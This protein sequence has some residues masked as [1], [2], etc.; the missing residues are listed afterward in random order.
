LEH[1]QADQNPNVRE[2]D[3]GESSNHEWWPSYWFLRHVYAAA[4]PRA[5]QVEVQRNSFSFSF[6]Y[7]FSF[8]LVLRKL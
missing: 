6:S 3:I 2:E 5:P 7:T 4:E 1:A 8:K